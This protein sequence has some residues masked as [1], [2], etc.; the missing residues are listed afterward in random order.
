MIYW[1]RHQGGEMAKSKFE[2]R[3]VRGDSSQ[4]QK[5]QIGSEGDFSR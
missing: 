2:H 5:N 4:E 3:W 1:D